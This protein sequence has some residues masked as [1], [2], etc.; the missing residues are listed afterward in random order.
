KDSRAVSAPS[1]PS[2]GIIRLDRIIVGRTMSTRMRPAWT[3]R[4]LRYDAW[5]QDELRNLLCGLPPNPAVD[6]PLAQSEPVPSRQEVND[7]FVREELLR[8]EADRHIRDGVASG[9]LRALAPGD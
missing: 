4:Y 3:D 1:V 7:R 5:T 8:I 6:T 2:D 9:R